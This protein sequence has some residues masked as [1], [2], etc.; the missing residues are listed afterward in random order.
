MKKMPT[1]FVREFENH[2]IVKVLDEVTEG[3]EW[4]LRGE[5]IATEKLDGTCTLYQNTILYKR[6]DAKRGKPVPQGAILCQ[7]EADAVTGHLPC[8]L[9]VS[10]SNPSDKWHILAFQNQVNN[11]YIFE[12]GQTYELCGVHFQNNP[13]DLSDDRYFK[14]GAILLRDVPRNYEGIRE[15]LKKHKIEGIVFHRGNGEMCKIKRSDFGFTWKNEK[16]R[17]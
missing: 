11:G 9:P 5:G 12:N 17:G 8:W 7:P 15:Y 2:K 4:V 6:Y 16:R 10:A 13:Y 1:L 14:H 3:C